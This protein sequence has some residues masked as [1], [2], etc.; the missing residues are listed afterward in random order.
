MFPDYQMPSMLKKIILIFV[1]S[2]L[3]LAVPSIASARTYGEGLYGRD[4]YQDPTTTTTTTSSN[5]SSA[6]ASGCGNNVTN[7]TPDLFEIRTNKNT[8]TLYFAPPTAPYSSFYIA[9][10]GKPDNWEYGVEFNQNYSGGVLNYTI[11]M[12]APN[13]K[14]YFKLRAGNGCAPG[15]WG[16]TMS[17]STT[18]STTRKTYYK[19]ILTAIVQQPK[20]ILKSLMPNKKTTT[21]KDTIL[22]PEPSITTEPK[23]ETQPQKPAPAKNKFCILWWCF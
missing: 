11:N 20:K 23:E 13:T 5:N 2:V 7:G 19:N 15:N 14:Y 12:L 4:N 9:F 1:F 16:N 22:K 21:K 18:K 3:C 17:A 6:S 10:S 8:A